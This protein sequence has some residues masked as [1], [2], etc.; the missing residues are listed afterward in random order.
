M[1]FLLLLVLVAI[2]GGSIGSSQVQNPP[3]GYIDT[4]PPVLI[5]D[6]DSCGSRTVEATEL[7]NIPNPAADQCRVVWSAT[8]HVTTLEI[9][10]LRGRVVLLHTVQSGETEALVNMSPL[11]QG[12]YAVLLKGASTYTEIFTTRH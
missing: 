2:V 12:V 9:V 6:S 4:M 5:R 7:R 3:G 10:D 11:P 1:I 8:M